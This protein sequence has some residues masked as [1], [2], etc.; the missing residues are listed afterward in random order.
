M[1][2]EIYD[3]NEQKPHF[4]HRTKLVLFI[5][6][7]DNIKHGQANQTDRKQDKTESLQLNNEEA[8]R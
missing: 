4:Q 1:V 5:E 7:Q 8:S 6:R 2:N 3:F